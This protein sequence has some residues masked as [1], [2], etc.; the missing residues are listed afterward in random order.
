MLLSVLR[1]KIGFP[2]P[3]YHAEIIVMNLF[4]DGGYY[5]RVIRYN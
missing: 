3:S 1:D 5:F 2:F 4:E